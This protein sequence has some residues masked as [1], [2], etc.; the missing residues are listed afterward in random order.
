MST[1]MLEI[2]TDNFKL[3]GNLSSGILLSIK[4]KIIISFHTLQISLSLINIITLYM[5]LEKRASKT[6]KISNAERIAIIRLFNDMDSKVDALNRIRSIK[7]LESLDESMI[8]DWVV[9]EDT[10]AC[11]QPGRPINE[12][13]EDEVMIECEKNSE[14]LCRSQVVR[15]GSSS[16]RF[17]YDHIRRC[18]RKLLDTLYWDKSSN[19]YS[20]KWTLDKRV[21]KLHFTNKWILGLLRRQSMKKVMRSSHHSDDVV[22][23][24]SIPWNSINSSSATST[25]TTSTTSSADEVV[26]R[27]GISNAFLNEEFDDIGPDIFDPDQ[28]DHIRRISFEMIPTLDF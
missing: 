26:F 16:N 20:K 19:S 24:A 5:K 28:E 13:F 3:A 25:T 23:T 1:S 6:P 7:G 17:S 22:C 18:A 11:K 14:L 8:R 4:I 27:D 10:L 2:T 21:S 15:R 9:V 12:D